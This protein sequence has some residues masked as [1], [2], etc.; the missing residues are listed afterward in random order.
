MEKSIV[1]VI[2]PTFNSEKTIIR[3]LN[4][5]LNQTISN[6]HIYIVDDGSTDGTIDIL[7][8]YEKSAKINI[9]YKNNEGVSVARNV[10]LNRV[11]TKYVTFLDSD[12]Y[13]NK[14]YLQDMISGFAFDDIDLVIS[15][16][17]YLQDDLSVQFKTNFVPHIYNSVDGINLLLNE[18]G[19]QGYV[20]SKL[21]KTEIVKKFNLSFSRELRM[22]EDLTFCIQYILHSQKINLISANNYNY[23]Q[24][25]N[26][27]SHSATVY[28]R[29]ANFDIAYLNYLNMAINLKKIIPMDIKYKTCK[30][31]INARTARISEDFLRTMY[32]NKNNVPVNKSLEKNLK[33]IMKENSRDLYISTVINNSQKL[34]F[35]MFIHCPFLMK[36]IDR[37][38]F[39]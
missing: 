23:I 7:K 21:F 37:K 35:W 24:Y 11:N 13:V 5:I 33:N 22:G 15:G 10:A 39:R 29:N 16:R 19:P 6:Y 28:N 17:V 3:C 2:I 20:T 34:Y 27:L 26:S 4:S 18:Q 36:M 12:D 9:I 38:R 14:K 32:L 1:S 30:V 31:N 8:K 25:K